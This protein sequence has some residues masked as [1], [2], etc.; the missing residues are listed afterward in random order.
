[1]VAEVKVHPAACLKRTAYVGDDKARRKAHKGNDLRSH[2]ALISAT[3]KPRESLDSSSSMVYASLVD[4]DVIYTFRFVSSNTV[5]AVTNIWNGS[6]NLDPT[7]SSEWASI[8]ALFGQYRLRSARATVVPAPDTAATGKSNPYIAAGI[9]LG[10]IS[11]SPG[12]LNAAMAV[13]D[14]RVITMIPAM[15]HRDYQWTTGDMSSYFQFQ[16]VGTTGTPYAGA[17]GLFWYY[18]FANGT[19]STFQVVYEYEVDMRGRA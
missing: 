10:E 14:G 6:A 11:T 18:G 5:T 15:P 16:L 19:S 7:G 3:R 1:M 12:T 17:Y 9:N 13:P 8:S 2:Q 4:P